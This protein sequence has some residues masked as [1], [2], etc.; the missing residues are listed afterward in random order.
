MCIAS[1]AQEGFEVMT[2]RLCQYY[3]GRLQALDTRTY[4]LDTEQ[5]K[6]AAGNAVLKAMIGREPDLF[7]DGGKIGMFRVETAAEMQ[8]TTASRLVGRYENARIEGYWR[9]KP[10]TPMSDRRSTPLDLLPWPEAG[11][12]SWPGQAAFIAALASVERRGRGIETFRQMGFSTCRL[13]GMKNGTGEFYD[14]RPSAAH[15]WRW[16]EGYRHYVEDHNVQPSNAFLNYIMS[17]SANLSVG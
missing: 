1:D 13:C 4:S 16:P 2:I 11:A 7:P 12:T 9:D 6:E 3:G 10:E 5:G 8:P 14:P 15:G 17:R